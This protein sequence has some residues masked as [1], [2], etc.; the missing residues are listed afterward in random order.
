MKK[1]FFIALL[2]LLGLP[3]MVGAQTPPA[4]SAQPLTEDNIDNYLRQSGQDRFQIFA[5]WA[6]YGGGVPK[7]I[8]LVIADIVRV[9][10][11]F[12]GI[13]LI[14]LIL[15]GGFMWM[16]SAGNEDRV[17]KAKKIIV[18]ATIGITIVFV[19][20]AIAY[21]ISIWLAGAVG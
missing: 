21:S 18:N 12:V 13:L 6:G 14:L 20:Y 1:I 10:L 8:E 7:P 3:F 15:Y 4:P 11:G 9:I 16:T 17:S 5:G 2:I 19:S